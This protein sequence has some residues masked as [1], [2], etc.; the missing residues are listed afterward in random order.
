M[1]N[2]STVDNALKNAQSQSEKIAIVE[3]ILNIFADNDISVMSNMSLQK[4]KKNS[5]IE[6]KGCKN[7]WVINSNDF[8]FDFIR[9]GGL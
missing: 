1:I 9:M 2:L 5:P 4:P 6:L 7:I 8:D 3:A